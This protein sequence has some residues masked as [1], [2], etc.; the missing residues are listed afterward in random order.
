MNYLDDIVTCNNCSELL[1][2]S[3]IRIV[4]PPDENRE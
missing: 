4:F 1:P 3:Y 2:D